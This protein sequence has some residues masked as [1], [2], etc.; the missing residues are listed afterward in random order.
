MIVMFGL[1]LL[2]AIVMLTLAIGWARIKT[3]PLSEK[4]FPFVSIIIPARNEENN[5]LACLANLIQQ[6]YPKEKLEIIV[7]NDHSEDETFQLTHTFFKSL[8]YDAKVLDL[9]AHL[10]G[11][12]A[13]LSFGIENSIGEIIITRDADTICDSTQWILSMSSPFHHKQINMVIGPVLLS[14]TNN[15]IAKFQEIENLGLQLI[16][17]A[18]IQIGNPVLSSGANLAF[19]KKSFLAAGDDVYFSKIASG[20]DIFIMNKFH[21]LFP[22]SIYFSKNKESEIIT[23]PCTSLGS[24]LEQRVRW[25]SKFFFVNNSFHYFI[26]VITAIMNFSLLFSLISSCFFMEWCYIFVVLTFS[27]FVI[28]FLLVFLSASFFGKTRL[29]RWFLPSFVVNPFYVSLVVAF[30]IIKKPVWKG[31]KKVGK[32]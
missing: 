15:F 25:A 19:R 10:S 30:S 1:M 7:V 22:Q 14:G 29:L 6:N 11:K 17:G 13:A 26:G 18:T 23:T 8:N 5:I 27:R 28:D 12:K 24:L 31:R 4:Y 9:P 32:E 2:Y 3:L 16:A 20:D 21:Q